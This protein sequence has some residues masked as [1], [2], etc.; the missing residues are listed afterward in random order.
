MTFRGSLRGCI[1]ELAH[2]FDLGNYTILSI[3]CNPRGK[4]YSVMTD[5]QL[6][7]KPETE[8]SSHMRLVFRGTQKELRTFCKYE[9][10][11]LFKEEKNVES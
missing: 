8:E 10:L 7:D 5:S 4:Y 3:I 9:Q 1:L 6:E 11:Q 2:Q